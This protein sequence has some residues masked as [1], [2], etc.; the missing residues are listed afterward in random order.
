MDATYSIEL[1][2]ARY[3]N[4]CYSV[5]GHYTTVSKRLEALRRHI[6]VWQSLDWVETRTS[7]PYTPFG[8]LEGGVYAY[9]DEFSLSFIQLPSTL[10]GTNIR[11]WSHDDIGVL[12][13]YFTMD[14]ERDLLVLIGP[15]YVFHSARLEP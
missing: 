1:A 3:E 2:R 6:S 10:R 11:T 8:T 4:N 5:K 7:M 14:P 9:G 12:I 15:V 13:N